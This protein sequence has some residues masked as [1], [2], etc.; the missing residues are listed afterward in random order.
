MARTAEQRPGKV[1]N[2]IN[3]AVETR[4]A[5]EYE[6][7]AKGSQSIHL[8]IRT[9]HAVAGISHP[10]RFFSTLESLGL[11]VIPHEFPDH[12][13]FT[14]EDVKFDDNIP[15]VMTEKDAVKLDV[16]RAARRPILVSRS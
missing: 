10:G 7:R 16:T 2:S 5:G 11:A 1:A 9:V 15:V 12:H 8:A 13:A 3:D 14:I 4:Q 6:L